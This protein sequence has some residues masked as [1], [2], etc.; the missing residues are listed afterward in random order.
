MDTGIDGAGVETTLSV[1][2]LGL[3]QL[4]ST[5]TKST[6][7]TNDHLIT[8]FYPEPGHVCSA[9]LYFMCEYMIPSSMVKRT[10][11]PKNKRNN[12][13]YQCIAPIKAICPPPS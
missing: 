8:E 5:I 7:T 10:L 6:L 4:R 13:D 12:R 9:S 1:V 11:S 3:A 2:R